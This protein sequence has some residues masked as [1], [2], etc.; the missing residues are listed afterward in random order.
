MMGASVLV[1]LVSIFFNWFTNDIKK[2]GYRNNYPKKK[3]DWLRSQNYHYVLKK[4]RNQVAKLTRLEKMQ[5][6]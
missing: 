4:R 1:E 6:P 2:Y 3:A 5:V